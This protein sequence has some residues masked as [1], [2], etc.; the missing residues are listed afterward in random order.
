L[1]TELELCKAEDS[2]TSKRWI[3][4]LEDAGKHIEAQ[5][6][7]LDEQ[8][9]QFKKDILY[10]GERGAEDMASFFSD[11]DK[12]TQ[13]FQT[14]VKYNITIRKKNE[15]MAKKEAALAKK[16]AL[17]EKKEAAK[18]KKEDAKRRKDDKKTPSKK[19]G[20]TDA[21]KPGSKKGD[22][23]KE[24]KKTNSFYDRIRGSVGPDIQAQKNNKRDED[25]KRT[26]GD[27]DKKPTRINKNTSMLL[28]DSV[29][30]SHKKPSEKAD[31]DS[32]V[33]DLLLTVPEKKKDLLSSR[34]SVRDSSGTVRQ[35]VTSLRTSTRFSKMR[36]QRSAPTQQS[37]SLETEQRLVKQ[38]STRLPKFSGDDLD[39]L[40]ST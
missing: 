22:L 27:D 10:F 36:D 12:F 33:D 17:L 15:A 18:K 35:L 6:K 11:W 14:A 34:G 40:N 4:Y 2:S 26:N 28:N 29:A 7:V 5:L 32:M 13:S 20:K 1:K 16:Q 9:T 21:K 38:V 8:D 23:K 25:D 19:R 30:Y 37:V 24:P 31:V 39:K 3:T